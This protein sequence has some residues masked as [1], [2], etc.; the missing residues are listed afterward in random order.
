M[1]LGILVTMVCLE[2]MDE[3]EQRVTKGMQENQDILAVQGRMA[4]TARKENKEQMEELKQKASK[5]IQAPEDP[6]GNMGQRDL[7]APWGRKASEERLV[8]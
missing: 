5:E 2:E 3:M 1:S 8:L 4:C 7:L 6:Q